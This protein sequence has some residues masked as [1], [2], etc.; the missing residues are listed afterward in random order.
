MRL[1]RTI[2]CALVLGAAAFGSANAEVLSLA[3]TNT[4]PMQ[5]N[6]TLNIW[7]DFSDNSVRQQNTIVG[8]QAYP[9]TGPYPGK[10]SNYTISYGGN[11]YGNAFTTIDRATG[12]LTFSYPDGTGEKWICEKSSTPPPAMKF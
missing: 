2:A 4:K 6:M 7:V 9:V 12:A 1:T 10:V 11:A 5:V 8:G 3:C